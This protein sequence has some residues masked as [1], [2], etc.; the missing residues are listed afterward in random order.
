[1]AFQ[2]SSYLPGGF[3][4]DRVLQII[5]ICQEPPSDQPESKNCWTMFGRLDAKSHHSLV[6]KVLPRN[7]MSL[8]CCQ[9]LPLV[10]L[11]PLPEY[12][13]YFRNTMMLFFPFNPWT[14]SIPPLVSPLSL[15]FSFVFV[16]VVHLCLCPLS[17]LFIHLPVPSLLRPGGDRHL[18]PQ[19]RP[20]PVNKCLII[21][22]L[23][24][25]IETTTTKASKA[26]VSH[27][28]IHTVIPPNPARL[29]FANYQ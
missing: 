20:I 9:A 15:Y 19:E 10:F 5:L 22:A 17:C 25:Q 28:Y 11:S 3:L 8:P 4:S 1:M 21:E 18:H 14:T 23:G 13:V 26:S 16:C 2:V 27:L 7:K 6:A 12:L 24:Q 29:H